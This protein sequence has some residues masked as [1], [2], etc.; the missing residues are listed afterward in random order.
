MLASLFC[1]S[2]RHADWHSLFFFLSRNL[3]QHIVKAE[4]GTEAVSYLV[5]KSCRHL[6]HG[7]EC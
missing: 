5:L 6:K 3:F 4:Y 7:A 1:R 2:N